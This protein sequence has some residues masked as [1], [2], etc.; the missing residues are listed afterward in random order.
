MLA[1][2]NDIAAS[3]GEPRVESALDLMTFIEK[4]AR[5]RIC[6]RC[7]DNPSTT[8]CVGCASSPG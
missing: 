5:P 2:V 7:K 3:R 8:L 6:P 4:V 1:R